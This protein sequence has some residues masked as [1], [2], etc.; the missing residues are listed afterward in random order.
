MALGSEDN[1]FSFCIMDLYILVSS[2]FSLM[3]LIGLYL[4][5]NS[6]ADNKVKN[7]VPGFSHWF[8]QV[9]RYVSK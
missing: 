6:V 1:D 4:I 7:S 8:G 2:N 5:H 9:M 3:F